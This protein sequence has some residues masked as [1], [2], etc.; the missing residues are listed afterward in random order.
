MILGGLGEVQESV[1]AALGAFCGASW[2]V[3]AASWGVLAASWGVL[4]GLRPAWVHFS[5]FKPNMVLQAGRG[6]QF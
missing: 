3:L 1:F 5:R 2:A 6:R 4:G